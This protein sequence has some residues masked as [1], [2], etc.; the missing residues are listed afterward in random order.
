MCN[1]RFPVTI[2]IQVPCYGVFVVIFFKTMYNNAII[3]FSFSDILNNQGLGKCYHPPPS[4][5]LITCVTLIIPDITKTSSIIIRYI[6]SSY[7]RSILTTT[8]FL[9]AVFISTFGKWTN[10]SS[11]VKNLNWLET[12]KSSIN[13]HSW[14]CELRTSENK[15]SLLGLKAS[16]LPEY[17]LDHSATLQSHFHK[18]NKLGTGYPFHSYFKVT[19]I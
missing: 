16:L 18:Q 10:H 15:S 4:A 11:K 14:G 8:I 13:K 1:A 19:L 6:L 9:W 2:S 12:K 17:H 7:L 5:Q 3:R